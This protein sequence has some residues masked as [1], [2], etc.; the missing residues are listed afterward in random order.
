MSGSNF[1]YWIASINAGIAAFNVISGDDREAIVAAGSCAVFLLA[2]V[3]FVLRELVALMRAI[4]K[5]K[6][7]ITFTTNDARRRA[8]ASRSEEY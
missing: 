7:H 6:T 3:L 5:E 2:A 8:V 1:L 4:A